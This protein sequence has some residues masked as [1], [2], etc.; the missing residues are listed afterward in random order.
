MPVPGKDGKYEWAGYVPYDQLPQSF[1][2]PKHF[3]NSSNNDVVPKIVPGYKIPLGY[4][5]GAPYR[6]DGLRRCWREPQVLG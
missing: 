5:Y 2:T 1:D 3:Y 6:Y 4:E